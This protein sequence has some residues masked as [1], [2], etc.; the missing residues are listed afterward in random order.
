MDLKITWKQTKN[1]VG[2]ELVVAGVIFPTV[3]NVPVET[4]NVFLADQF[5][6][7]LK[8]LATE[9]P[10]LAAFELVDVAQ[11]DEYEGFSRWL[12]QTGS[13]IVT[14]EVFDAWLEDK[15]LP[16]MRAVIFASPKLH[17][18]AERAS[19]WGIWKDQVKMTASKKGTFNT[20]RLTQAGYRTI[21][22]RLESSDVGVDHDSPEFAEFLRRAKGNEARPE[23]KIAELPE[24]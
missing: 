5:K 10:M 17:T 18:E 21:R 14:T 22:Q 23:P 8:E 1:Q 3:D 13:S 16:A 4:I 7:Y 24:V 15:L 20:N 2:R 12:E 6:D 11:G 9:S 19:T